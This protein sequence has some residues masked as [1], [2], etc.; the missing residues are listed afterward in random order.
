MTGGAHDRVYREFVQHLPVP[1]EEDIVLGVNHG[2]WSLISARTLPSL[3]HPVLVEGGFEEPEGIGF[4]IVILVAVIVV[5]VPIII[6]GTI[7]FI[8]PVYNW[9][10]PSS[11]ESE[12]ST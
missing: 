1:S 11:R 4:V 10:S 7:V 9:S 3:A 8:L 2:D 5:F 12:M 6:V